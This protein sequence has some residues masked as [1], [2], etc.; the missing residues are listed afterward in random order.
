[1]CHQERIAAA[2]KTWL[3]LQAK[4]RAIDVFSTK[5]VL[6]ND[7]PTKRSRSLFAASL[8]LAQAFVVCLLT[9]VIG[10]CLVPLSAAQQGSDDSVVNREY[11]LKALFL[12]NFGGYI[13]WPA[14]AFRG[15]ND[16]FVIGI[17][18][19]APLD[20]TLRE[21]SA[22]R[23]IAGRAIGIERFGSADKVTPCQILFIGRDVSA[24]QQ[25]AAVEKLKRH[26]VLIV[27]ESEGFAGRGASVNFFVESNKIRFEIN[28]DVAREEQLKISA[29]LLALA[30]IVQKGS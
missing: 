14:V 9:F 3:D 22:T 13:E 11:P 30:K 17:L 1:M 6:Q 27:G 12:Y 8:K 4:P 24:Q 20:H 10:L 7:R 16:P 25:H 26:H 23:K 15:S 5:C 19:S 28:L 18:G 2:T 29:K 21:I